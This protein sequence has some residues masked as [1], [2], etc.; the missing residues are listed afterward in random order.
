MPP[1]VASVEDYLD[2]FP[3]LDCNVDHDFT[4]H[5]SA[6]GNADRCSG[7]ASTRRREFKFGPSGFPGSYH[8]QQSAQTRTRA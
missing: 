1:E 2:I 4:I 7:V 6:A 5:L 3:Q 8:K